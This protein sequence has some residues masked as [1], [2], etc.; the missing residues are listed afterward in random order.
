MPT[1]PDSPEFKIKEGLR[2]YL[3]YALRAENATASYSKIRGIVQGPAQKNII[4]VLVPE[5]VP[6]DDGPNTRSWECTVIIAIE[7]VAAHT[8][9]HKAETRSDAHDAAAWAVEQVMDPALVKAYLNS[10]NI[11]EDE[12]LRPIPGFAISDFSSPSVT[13][14][15][16]FNR[17]CFY[18]ALKFT[19]VPIYLSDCD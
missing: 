17:H 1:L 6:G 9:E 12:G 2:A 16:D 8:S 3:S 19:K 4:A 10:E 18:T 11:A 13:S 14:G 15:F 5:R 7:T